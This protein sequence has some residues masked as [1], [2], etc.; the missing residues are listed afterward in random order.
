MV[1]PYM[2]MPV[3]IIP[4]IST[5]YNKKIKYSPKTSAYLE[6]MFEYKKARF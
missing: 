6:K 5:N 4:T 2:K 1:H 3:E